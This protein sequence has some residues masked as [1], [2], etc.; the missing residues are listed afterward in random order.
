[1]SPNTWFFSSALSADVTV[2]DNGEIKI[3]GSRSSWYG[4][5]APPVNDATPYIDSGYYRVFR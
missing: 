2:S 3:E 5:I 1:M 4:G